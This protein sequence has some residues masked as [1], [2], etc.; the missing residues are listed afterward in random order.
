MDTPRPC[1]RFPR[2]LQS[3]GTAK[4]CN[5][6]ELHGTETVRSMELANSQFRIE[7][8]NPTENFAERRCATANIPPLTTAAAR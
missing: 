2:I 4:L 6:G 1:P 7:A 3:P 8:R 5:S